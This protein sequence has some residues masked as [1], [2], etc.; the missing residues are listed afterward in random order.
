MLDLHTLSIVIHAASATGAFIIGGS[1]YFFK[2][3]RFGNYN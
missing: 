1:S 3:I 2:A